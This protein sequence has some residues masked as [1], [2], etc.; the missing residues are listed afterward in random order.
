MKKGGLKSLF[1]DYLLVIKLFLTKKIPTT[2]VVGILKKCRN[3]RLFS[4]AHHVFW[5]YP[6]IKFFSGKVTGVYCFFS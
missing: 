6:F 1:C 5:A 2:T 3:A 4:S